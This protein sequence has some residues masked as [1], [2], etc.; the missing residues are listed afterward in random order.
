MSA[1]GNAPSGVRAP[2]GAPVPENAPTSCLLCD[3]WCLEGF[4][5]SCMLRSVSGGI[6]HLLDHHRFCVVD[7]DPDAGMTYRDSARCV[8]ALMDR[9]GVD[10]VMAGEFPR[11]ALEDVRRWAGLLS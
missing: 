2:G 1:D 9:F 3:T 8:D 10:D 7:G 11:P 4:H 5:R 6:G